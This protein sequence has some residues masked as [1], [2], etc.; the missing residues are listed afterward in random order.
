[1]CNRGGECIICL[2]VNMEGKGGHKNVRNMPLEQSKE[3]LHKNFRIK[4]DLRQ[5]NTG[6][7]IITCYGLRETGCKNSV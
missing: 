7:E 4:F 2:A 3:D 5:Q 6:P 1:M